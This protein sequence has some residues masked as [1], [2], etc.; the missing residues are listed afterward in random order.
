MRGR[1]S[2]S[3]FVYVPGDPGLFCG[4]PAPQASEIPFE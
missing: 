2:G 4:S 3:G 1:G